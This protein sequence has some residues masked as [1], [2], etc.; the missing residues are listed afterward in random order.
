MTTYPVRL[1]AKRR[2]TLPAELLAEAGVSPESELVAS[3]D[4]AGRIVVETRE[5]LVA[6]IR[7]RYRTPRP[8]PG[9][10]Q[11]WQE[12]HEAEVAALDAR[13]GR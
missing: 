9:L 8:G 4:G 5:A 13:A 7:G 3:T 6:R 11:A 1:D 12:H 10:A 2:P